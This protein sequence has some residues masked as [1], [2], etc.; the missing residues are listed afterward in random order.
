MKTFIA[1]L[2]AIA[3]VSCATEQQPFLRIELDERAKNIVMPQALCAERKVRHLD[4]MVSGAQSVALLLSMHCR[5]EYEKATE[6]YARLFLEDEEQQRTFRE[7]RDNIQEKIEA[8]LPAV[9]EHRLYYTR[10]GRPPRF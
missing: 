1:A 3:C 7:G 9:M 2:C 6:D 5:H 4:N 10:W 8:F